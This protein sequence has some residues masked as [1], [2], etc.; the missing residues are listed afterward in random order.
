MLGVPWKL[1]CYLDA[2]G[3]NPVEEFIEALPVA[4]RASLRARIDFLAEIGNRAS[5]P[6]SKSLADR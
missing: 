5:E 3:N 4:D 1:E 6:L 2:R